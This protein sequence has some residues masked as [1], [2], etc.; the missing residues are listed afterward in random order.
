MA[1]IN[2][3]CNATKKDGYLCTSIIPQTKCRCGTHERVFNNKTIRNYIRDEIK[4]RTGRMY[5]YVT[6]GEGEIVILPGND[7]E[8]IMRHIYVWRT[9]ATQTFA[10]MTDDQ[11]RTLLTTQGYWYIR[12]HPEPIDQYGRI[13]L[14]DIPPPIQ[15]QRQTTNLGDFVQDK[16]NVHLTV[17]VKQTIDIV[18]RVL[19]IPVPPEYRWNT[20]TLSKTPGEII[21]CCKLTPQ[22]GAVMTDKYSRDDDVY[23]L[24]NGIYGKVL[25]S[26]WQ[27]ISKSDDKEHMCAILKQELQDN[28][29]MCAQGN[30]SRLCNALAG[31][32]EGI[33]EIESP[34]EKLGRLIPELMKIEDEKVRIEKV[35]ELLEN[36][37]LP[38]DEWDNWLNAVY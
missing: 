29:G 9:V 7:I 3:R 11:I 37:S 30:L 16:Q 22:A 23:E 17:T 21:V 2:N 28:I 20:E 18:N 35:K 14:P 13:I 19:K 12:G 4:S 25:D 10:R 24:G 32:M 33:G 26:V 5:R 27:Y 1:L 36:V 31:Y 8:A 34:A 15:R 6:A 38:R